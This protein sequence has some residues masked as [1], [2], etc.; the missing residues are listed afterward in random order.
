M[1]GMPQRRPR[2]EVPALTKLR[3]PP[4]VWHRMTDTERIVALL[5]GN[6]DNIHQCV[7]I[8]YAEADI[9]TRNNHVRIFEIS[10]KAGLKLHT[11][12][13]RDQ[14]REQALSEL[15]RALIQRDART[16]AAS[17]SEDG[18]AVDTDQPQSAERKQHQ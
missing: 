13:E 3:V 8:P 4:D 15:A 18:H 16:H 10:V 2:R 12:R 7:S 17:G 11:D 14:G 5:G 6:L 1:A 9:H